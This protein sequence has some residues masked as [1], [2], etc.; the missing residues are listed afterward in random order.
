M[1][2]IMTIEDDLLMAEDLMDKLSGLGYT[3]VGNARNSE[4]ALA[5]A[6][7]ERPEIIIADIMLEDSVDGIETVRDILTFHLCPV[8][9]LTANSE[10]A[11]VKKGMATHPAAFMLKPYKISEFSINIDL[12]ISNFKERYPK[13]PTGNYELEAIYL[14][15]NYLYQRVLK[16]DILYVEADGGYVR[17]VTP[18]KTYPLTTNLKTF[19][20][21]FNHPDFYRVSR[22][23]FVNMRRVEKINGNLLYTDGPEGHAHQI[24]ISRQ[25]R[26]AILAR[27][28]IIKTK[29][30]DRMDE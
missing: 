16:D 9:Y 5:M 29:G 14:A 19:I 1:Y 24:S 23:H 26:N 2:R 3:M 25:E 6:Q 12:A 27:F 11:T 4:E 28:A 10:A 7:K 15:D 22:K 13:M 17:V 21:Q 18:K 20:E 8:I 30:G